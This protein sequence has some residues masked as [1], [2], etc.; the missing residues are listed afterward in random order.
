MSRLQT[1]IVRTAVTHQL[2]ADDLKLCRTVKTSANAATLQ[3]A[4]VRLQQWYTNW[5]LTINTK[6]CFVLH[7]GKTNSQIQ[8]T[9][10]GCLIDIAQN[11][12]DLG[13][14]IDCNLK[15]D[16]L[17]NNIISKAYAR[18]YRC[19]LQGLCFA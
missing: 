5:Q 14:E 3:S 4:L 19:P 7:L 16:T 12:T 8:Y 15:Y 2:F 1:D 10:D 9:L 13:V 11:V 6:K 17:I 18:V